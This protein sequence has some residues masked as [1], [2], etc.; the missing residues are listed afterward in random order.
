SLLHQAGDVELDGAQ[1][2]VWFRGDISVGLALRDGDREA[3]LALGQGD[4][5]LSGGWQAWSRRGGRAGG[6]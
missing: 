4:D 1:A 6:R 2:D 5:R 3:F